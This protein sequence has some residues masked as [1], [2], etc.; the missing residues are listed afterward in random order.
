MK[1]PTIDILN[2]HFNVSVTDI[3]TFLGLFVFISVTYFIFRKN[4]D[5]REKEKET[6]NR[7]IR[8]ISKQQDELLNAAEGNVKGSTFSRR[9]SELASAIES[10]SGVID[11]IVMIKKKAG[12]NEISLELFMVVCLVGGVVFA[13]L[14]VQFNF[15]NAIAGIPVGLVVGSYLAFSFLKMQA[16]RKRMMFLQEFPEAIDMM[17]RGVKAGLNIGRIMKLVSIEAREPLASE[18]TTISQKFDLGIEPEKVLTD[19]AEMINLE[20]FRF[21]VVAL[22]LQMENGGTLSDILQNLADIV[23]KRLE[24]NL[25]LKAMSAEARMSAIVISV[26]PFVFGGIMAIVNP[27]HMEEFLNPGSG[28]TLLKVLIVLFCVGTFCM[29]KATKIKV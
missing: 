25:K 15:L 21:L 1:I 29:V 14:I 19:A 3:V 13:T 4:Q 10:K 16:E 23:R 22:I 5:M 7:R 12:I 11:K 27:S 9:R 26:L 20:E 18:F 2:F 24:L 17:I 28:R 8:T 6:L